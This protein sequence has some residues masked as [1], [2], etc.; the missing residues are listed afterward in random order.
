VL[1]CIAVCYI[2][3]QC[4]AVCYNVLQCVALRYSSDLS[5]LDMVRFVLSIV[6]SWCS[7]I[8]TVAL[9]PTVLKGIRLQKC[10]IDSFNVKQMKYSYTVG[11]RH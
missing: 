11:C 4:F 10:F 6:V 1:R 9:Q 8:V 2:A 3:L 5:K 7:G